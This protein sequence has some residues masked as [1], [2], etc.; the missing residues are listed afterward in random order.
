[1][2]R[3][4]VLGLACAGLFSASSARAQIPAGSEA[5]LTPSYFRAYIIAVCAAAEEVNDDC[6]TQGR[7]DAAYALSEMYLRG[8]REQPLWNS[9][10]V[11][12]PYGWVEASQSRFLRDIELE[13]IVLGK[14]KIASLI[15]G[16]SA[17]G[18]EAQRGR[19]EAWHIR[20]LA[21][22]VGGRNWSHHWAENRHEFMPAQ[23]MHHLVQTG[24]RR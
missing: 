24:L 5:H 18:A 15:A 17:L 13:A 16:E 21:E 3:S 8:Y 2:L 1:M 14:E 4:I 19:L 6:L 9:L 23:V 20:V 12:F 11:R 7:R 10:R 22:V